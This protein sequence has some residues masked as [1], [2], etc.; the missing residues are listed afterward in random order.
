MANYVVL[1]NRIPELIMSCMLCVSE[2]SQTCLI[3]K[4]LE[5][6]TK[7]VLNIKGTYVLTVSAV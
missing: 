6:Y 5:G 1:A 2:Y 3:R 7:S 4:H